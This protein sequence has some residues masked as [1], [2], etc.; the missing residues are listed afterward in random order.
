MSADELL[1]RRYHD[2]VRRTR[3]LCAKMQITLYEYDDAPE[4]AICILSRNDTE[5]GNER[6]YCIDNSEPYFLSNEGYRRYSGYEDSDEFLFD[7]Q[8]E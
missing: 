2:D 5:L 7:E 1:L 6:R 8:Y 3:R 4:D